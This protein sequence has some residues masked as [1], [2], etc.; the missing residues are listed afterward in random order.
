MHHCRPRSRSDASGRVT[1]IAIDRRARESENKRDEET[2]AGVLPAS[3]RLRGQE[4]AGCRDSASDT[5]PVA[6][7]HRRNHRTLRNYQ[8]G[9]CQH[10]DL[11]LSAHHHR[12]RFKDGT[13]QA[14]L[15]EN[16]R[17]IMKPGLG[18]RR[19]NPIIRRRRSLLSGFEGQ[20]RLATTRGKT[21]NE[22]RMETRNLGLGVLQ[23]HHV[24]IGMSAEYA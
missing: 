6:A 7:S 13:H 3:G 16:E 21:V 20:R 14:G 24:G 15:Q 17:R 18:E 22:R 23:Q 8:A 12:D 11:Q 1:K 5:E 4:A 19:A 2:L 9:K 10:R